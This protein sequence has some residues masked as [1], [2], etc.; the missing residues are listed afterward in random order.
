MDRSS[1]TRRARTLY[2][3]AGRGSTLQ[4]RIASHLHDLGCVVP[5]LHARV[6]FVAQPAPG[7]SAPNFLDFGRASLAELP[8]HPE[9]SRT[10][11][12]KLTV[13]SG[14]ADKP[15]YALTLERINL[16]RC[17]EV[18][19]SGTVSSERT[20]SRSRMAWER[21]TTRSR[22]H[23]R[24]DFDESTKSFRIA[25][26]RSAHGTAIVRNGRTIG[27]PSGSRDATPVGDEVMLGEARIRV[28][29]AESEQ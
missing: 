13:T 12:V 2:G 25:D 21:P 14:A 10:H 23:A 1:L 17:A 19:D 11:E 6:V 22:R 8:Q 26:D 29:I 9:S 16:G 4:E 28:R 27:V 3:G 18:R 5:S 24:I 20:T 7:W 15:T